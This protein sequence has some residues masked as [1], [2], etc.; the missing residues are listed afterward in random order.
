MVASLLL[1]LIGY[2]AEPS[3]S[4]FHWSIPSILLAA[5]YLAGA[6]RVQ[7]RRSELQ[8]P[9]STLAALAV[10]VTAF[11]SLSIPLELNDRWIIVP[12]ALEVAALTAIERKVKIKTLDILAA[13]LTSVVLSLLILRLTIKPSWYWIL[14]NYGISAASLAVAAG[15][16]TSQEHSRAFQWCSILLFLM[17]ITLEAGQIHHPGAITFA[18][19]WREKGTVAIGW[20]AF[21][22]L[23]LSAAKRWDL[24]VPLRWSKAVCLLAA[25]EVFLFSC[26]VLNP[27]FY[28]ID[29][30]KTPVFNYLLYVYGAPAILLL[31]ISRHSLLKGDGFATALKA[32]SLV[33]IFLLMNF[34]IRQLFHGN[35]LGHRSLSTAEQYIYSAS[36][37]VFGIVLTL[38]A[39]LRRGSA[40]LRYASLVVLLMAVC[41]VFLYDSANLTDLY[42]VLSFLGLGMSLLGIA[43]LYQKVLFRVPQQP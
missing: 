4:S 37:V 15:L 6:F 18:R 32:V 21:A 20:L 26:V 14:Y 16:T 1:F 5:L 33:L 11:A 17:L 19:S 13:I 38:L 35:Y 2:S 8:S 40:M 41:K 23:L 39:T 28:D 36:W 29:V 22:L 7:R 24:N 9:T 34:E 12:F 27:L 31:L 30:G 10:A 25:A 3:G 42:R 43:Y